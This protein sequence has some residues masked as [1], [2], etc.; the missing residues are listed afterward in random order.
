LTEQIVLFFPTEVASPLLATLQGT[1][2]HLELLSL[3]SLGGLIYGGSPLFG[4]LENAFYLRF[5]LPNPGFIDPKLLATPTPLLFSPFSPGPVSPRHAGGRALAPHTVHL[6]G[7]PPAA[8]RRWDTGRRSR[9]GANLG[10]GF[11][12]LPGGVLD[13]AEPPLLARPG[14]ARR[15][16]RGAV[17]S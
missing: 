3:L 6:H 7:R 12:A 4:S 1:Q 16:G 14:V 2:A 9:L 17:V 8:R 11:P 15:A 10:L 13:R 5:R